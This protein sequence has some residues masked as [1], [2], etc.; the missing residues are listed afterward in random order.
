MA[1]KKYTVV[2]GNIG[3]WDFTNKKLALKDYYIYQNQSVSN[4]GR[5]S[6]ED[7]TLFEGDE[8]IKEYSGTINSEDSND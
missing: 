2:V 8:I 7:V 6:G 3:S 5:A 1:K 4:Y